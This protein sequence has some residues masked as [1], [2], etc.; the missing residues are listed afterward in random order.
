MHSAQ[1]K[2]AFSKKD[3]FSCIWHKFWR[4]VLEQSRINPRHPRI[5]SR[6]DCLPNLWVNINAH[7]TSYATAAKTGY[8]T[9]GICCFI[10]IRLLESHRSFRNSLL[11]HQANSYGIFCLIFFFLPRFFA[12]SCR[13]QSNRVDTWFA[14]ASN[15]NQ[16]LYTPSYER[17]A[18]HLSHLLDKQHQQDRTRSTSS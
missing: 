8:K 11:H 18:R 17:A 14:A 16:H 13:V 2:T 9:P 7:W 5:I 15:F 12:G 6:H 3:Y 10:I 1:I 4:N